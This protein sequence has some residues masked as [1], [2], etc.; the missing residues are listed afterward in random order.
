MPKST[1][2]S[3]LAAL[4]GFVVFSFLNMGAVPPIDKQTYATVAISFF[5]AAAIVSLFIILYRTEKSTAEEFG[6]VMRNNIATIIPALLINFV[7]VIV[8]LYGY[9]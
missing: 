1:S 8:E 5:N 9:F 6:T 3:L 7:M 4:I 2:F